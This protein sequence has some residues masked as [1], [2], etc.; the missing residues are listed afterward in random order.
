MQN[1]KYS[2]QNTRENGFIFLEILIAVALIDIAFVALLSIGVLSLNLSSSIQ[3]TTQ[4]NALLKEEIERV[5]KIGRAH[6]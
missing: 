4:V 3:K 6:V 2:I 5:R 1:T